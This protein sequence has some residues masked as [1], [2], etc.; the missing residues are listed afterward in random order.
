MNV[1][2]EAYEGGGGAGGGLRCKNSI[3]HFFVKIT[4]I[5]QNKHQLKMV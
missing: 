4:P 5:T 2:K 1:L 3:L